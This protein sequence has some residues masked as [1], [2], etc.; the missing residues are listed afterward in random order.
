MA[1][2]QAETWDLGPFTAVQ[3]CLYLD[4]PLFQ[5]QSTKKLHGTK[6][7][8]VHVQLGQIRT[9]ETNKQK[10]LPL[11]KSLEQRP[12]VRN[13]SRALHLAPA[14]TTP[15]KGWEKHLSRPLTQP[16]RSSHIRIRLA[17]LGVNNK[18]SCY[19]F[20]LPTAAAGAPR[21]PCLN[22]SSGL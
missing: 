21:R 19:L 3:Q 16:L 10:Q 13:K 7:N 8:C 6:N 11:L 14:H 22:F 18:G 17:P 5:Q 12:E 1:V 20:L 4:I 9:K 15:P 2:R